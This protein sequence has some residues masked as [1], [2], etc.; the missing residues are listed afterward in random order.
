[1]LENAEENL[2]SQL[3]DIFREVS[4]RLYETYTQIRKEQKPPVLAADSQNDP[5]V[6]ATDNGSSSVIETEQSSFD[7][8]ITG[9]GQ[10]SESWEAIS[11]NFNESFYLSSIDGI[12]SPPGAGVDALL[13]PD[14]GFCGLSGID[15]LPPN[16]E[17]AMEES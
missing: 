9:P 6:D 10:P 14:W 2:R 17:Q 3:P 5:H 16:E 7:A 8:S 11:Q 12:L 15:Q 1:L 13:T 4:I